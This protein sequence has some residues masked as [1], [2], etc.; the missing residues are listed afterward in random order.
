MVFE[1]ILL[2]QRKLAKLKIAKK[3]RR[4]NVMVRIN[5]AS[6]KKTMCHEKCNKSRKAKKLNDR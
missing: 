6:N 5:K 3:K 1:L 4:N 2:M